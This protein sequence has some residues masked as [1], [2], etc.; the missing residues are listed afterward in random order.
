M[1]SYLKKVCDYF[2]MRTPPL[3]EEGTLQK[4]KPEPGFEWPPPLESDNDSEIYNQYIAYDEIPE[5][6][7]S[8]GLFLDQ[9]FPYVILAGP[10]S[11]KPINVRGLCLDEMYYFD[12]EDWLYHIK[13]FG[14]PKDPE[15]FR[16]ILL[17]I[18]RYGCEHKLIYI[19]CRGGLGRTG[20]A[21]ACL[22]KLIGVEN[23]IG[24]VR[25]MYNMKAVETTGQ[26]AFIK[27]F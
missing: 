23:P 20:V 13:D 10:F 11:N 8:S 18:H 21:L 14:I 3:L 25:T 7:R 19:G 4:I 15:K 1:F 24:V 16:D 12:N 6:Y 27:G 17:E 26:V 22:L 9:S 5:I 2:L